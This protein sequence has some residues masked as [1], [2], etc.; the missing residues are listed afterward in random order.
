MSWTDTLSVAATVTGLGGTAVVVARYLSRQYSRT[1]G[2]RNRIAAALDQLGC[3][4]T[5]QYFDRILGEPP[6]RFMGS[7]EEGR[8]WYMS[9]HCV[10][11]VL[12]SKGTVKAFSVTS[13]D[14]YFQYN[15]ERLGGDSVVLGRDGFSAVPYSLV[16]GR[17]FSAGAHFV[18][19]AESLT[20][21]N[22][23]GYQ[24]YVYAYNDAGTGQLQL[25]S[26]QALGISALAQGDFSGD[27]P[28]EPLQDFPDRLRATRTGTTVNTFAVVG[29]LAAADVLPDWAPV[30]PESVTLRVFPPYL[31][32]RW[33][34]SPWDRFRQVFASQATGER[35]PPLH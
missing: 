21:G 12:T 24:T 17:L 23:G 4:V 22:P 34:S 27:E 15:V 3:G 16:S 28:A 5:V 9:P 31:R 8:S 32:A 2:S 35:F 20:R 18:W 7:D 19:Y 10:V 33:R 14:P 25:A 6:F 26:M 30:G 29:P 11:D 1:V 13:I